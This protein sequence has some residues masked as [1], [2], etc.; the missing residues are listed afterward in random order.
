MAAWPR[1]ATP[2]RGGDERD[3]GRGQR[4]STAAAS[5]TSP[6]EASLF[7][8][9]VSRSTFEAMQCGGRRR[10]SPTSAGGCD[11][12]RAARLRRRS[13]VVGPD[14]AAPD[15]APPRS[16]GTRA[17]SGCAT[18]SRATARELAGLLDRALDQQWIDAGPR[19]GKVGRRVLHAVRRGPFTGAAQ[20]GGLRSTRR[21]RPL[22]SSATPTTTPRWPAARRSRSGCRWRSPRPPASSARR[23][24]VE[25]GAGASGRCRAAGDA[26]RRPRRFEPGRRRHPRRFLFETE[27]FARRQRRTLGVSELNEMM[28]QAQADAY[29]DGLDLDTRH[30]YMW[31]LK[32]HYYGSHFYNWPYTYGLLFGL[33]LFAKYQE[34]PERFR[35][36]Y[37]DALSRAGIDDAE[38]LGATFGIDVT[39]E[40]VL[41]RQPRRVPRSAS[42]STNSSLTS[43]RPRSRRGTVMPVDLRTT[44]YDLTREQL[45]ERLGEVPRYRLDQV[46]SGLYSRFGEPDD[47]TDLPKAM[48]SSLAEQLPPALHP[49]TETAS[50][51]GD[52][53]KFLWALDGG[54][55]DRNR[56]DALPRPGNGVRVEPGGVRDGVRLLR[57][58][59]GRLHAS[60][61]GG[62]DRRAG[63]ARQASAPGSSSGACRTSCSWAWVSRSPTSPPCGSRSSGSITTSASRPATSRSARSGSSPASARWRR[64]HS[65]ST[66][67]CRCTPP[68]TSC[69][70]SWCRS[71]AATRSTI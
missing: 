71:T 56:A 61:H 9:N 65:R 39:S 12:R 38:Q 42:P 70:T 34:D 50:D 3:Q 51:K 59:P 48:R 63:G 17:S 35:L 41:D 44:R 64:G 67:Q 66:W 54:S 20:L 52:T 45:A 60:P 29:G 15:G 43:W 19:E 68:T 23:S 27:L 2:M 46:W 14:G 22:T 30:P 28:L 31:V 62:R 7:A 21:R 25:A 40:A 53:I 33:G 69:A 18:R 8:N 4:R 36:G 58:R 13:Q 32:P 26:R 55:P 1:I 24:A 6:L 5:G 11:A 57:H 47:W 49:V 16:R 10:R 37:A